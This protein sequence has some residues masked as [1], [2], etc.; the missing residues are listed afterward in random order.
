MLWS[1]YNRLRG[2]TVGGE[3]WKDFH[4]QLSAGPNGVKLEEADSLGVGLLVGLISVQWNL[5]VPQDILVSGELGKAEPALKEIGG[6]DEKMAVAERAPNFVKL[7]TPNNLAGGKHRRLC[8]V[9]DLVNEVWVEPKKQNAEDVALSR[10]PGYYRRVVNFGAMRDN[11][12]PADGGTFRGFCFEA[13]VTVVKARSKDLTPLLVGFDAEVTKTRSDA[14]NTL[15]A[16]FIKAA[17]PEFCEFFGVS[18]PEELTL[19]V[20]VDPYAVWN[21]AYPTGAAVAQLIAVAAELVLAKDAVFMVEFDLA[22]NRRV[23]S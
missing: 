8:T 21:T 12:E 2:V 13:A 22:G 5:P 9:E 15:R 11:L 20:Q 17:T 19:H 10:A 4:W 1:A 7:L 3:G 6:E 14:V 23:E 18:S 16:A